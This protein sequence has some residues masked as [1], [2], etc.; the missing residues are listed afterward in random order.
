MATTNLRPGVGAV[1][2]VLKKAV[3]SRKLIADKYPNYNAKF[4][5][6]ENCIIISQ[7][8]GKSSNV[9]RDVYYFRHDDFPNVELYACRRYCHI[10]EEG[11]AETLFDKDEDSANDSEAEVQETLLPQPTSDHREDIAAIVA[12]GLDVDDDNT[13]AP[14]NVPERNV[15]GAQEN[16]TY[17]DWGSVHIC[18]RSVDIT[19]NRRPNLQERPSGNDLGR[20]FLYLFPMEYVRQELLP[21]TNENIG[22]RELSEGEFLRYLG[23]WMLLSTVGSSVPKSDFWSKEEPNPFIGAPF[24]LRPYMPYYRWREITKALRYTT[25]EKPRYNDKVFEVRSML[26]AFNDL[27]DSIFT[28]GSIVCLDESMSPWT[29][30]YTCPAFVYCPRKP[31]PR[32]NEYH[33]IAD[34]ECG[35]MFRI[36]LVEGKDEP[37]D[38]LPKKKFHELPKTVALM[39]RM[40]EPLFGSGTIVVLDSGFCVL[41]ALIELRLRGVFA[42]AVIKKRRYWPKHIKGDEIKMARE[43]DEIGKQS[44]LP[45]S[46]NDIPFSIFTSMEPDYLLMMM[47]TYGTVLPN[48]LNK[49]AKRI[50]KEGQ[51]V[52][53]QYCNVIANHYQYRDAVDAHNAKRHDGG[54]QQGISIETTWKT[55]WW[56]NRVFAFVLGICEVNTYLALKHFANYDKTQME[57]RRELAHKLIYNDVEKEMEDSEEEINYSTRS[58][59]AQVEHEMVRFKKNSVWEDGRWVTFS[60]RKYQQRTCKTK[61]CNKRTRLYCKCS[62]GRPRCT[63]C[64]HLH[65]SDPATY[66]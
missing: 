36:E 55:D 12:A 25:K 57:F 4:D 7:G 18:N 62:L 60:K 51:L 66:S 3:H 15:R 8:Q 46:Y 21:A 38:V 56:P 42:A 64:L 13:P 30:M 19:R 16:V 65:L 53:I 44:R 31:H 61:G 45:G 14:E 34:G 54:T 37:R 9:Q 26:H 40:C 22:S 2:W 28:S 33:T 11:P 32:G 43:N 1:F 59:A 49:K 47:S 39:L 20:W 24:R 63:E 29:S 35:I 5:K 6:L 27:M 23:I 58:R 41:R 10:T 17:L 50:D 52:E 48:R